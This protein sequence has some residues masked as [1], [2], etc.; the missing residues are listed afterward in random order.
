MSAIELAFVSPALLVLIFLSIQAGLY[1]YGR[2]VAQQAAREGVSL[3]RVVPEE[4]EREAEADVEEGVADYARTVGRESLTSPVAVAD[5]DADEG[6]ASVVVT[7]EVITLVPFL[8]LSVT[9]RVEGT[10]ERFEADERDRPE[11]G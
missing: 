11:R 2:V 8:E 6:I 4:F 7:G 9:Q 3:L 5:Y 10:I 1:Y